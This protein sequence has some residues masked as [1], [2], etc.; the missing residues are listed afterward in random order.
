MGYSDLPRSA[1]F[2]RTLTSVSRPSWNIF[3]PS[4]SSILPRRQFSF[5]ANEYLGELQL[6]GHDPA[7]VMEPPFYV[8][9]LNQTG[10]GV[11]VSSMMYN[12]TCPQ[13]YS[14]RPQTP[15][16]KPQ[17]LSIVSFYSRLGL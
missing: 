2:F 6:G 8:K 11:A 7:S 15:D 3:Q 14:L 5:V 13:K 4:S 17:T 12:G 9:M 1:C 10:Y 16:P